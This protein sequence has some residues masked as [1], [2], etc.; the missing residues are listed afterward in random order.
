MTLRIALDPGCEWYLVERKKRI[1]SLMKSVSALVIFKS[2]THTVQWTRCGR[3]WRDIE[4]GEAVSHGLGSKANVR[5]I[6]KSLKLYS[7]CHSSLPGPPLTNNTALMT[8]LDKGVVVGLG[9]QSA[10]EARHARFDVRWV[11]D[12]GAL[13]QGRY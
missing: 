2:K 11:S 3:C 7:E 4:S 10:W 8:L 5:L 1:C 6:F 13:W 9:V 12:P